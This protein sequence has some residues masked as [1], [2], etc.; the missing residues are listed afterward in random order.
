MIGYGS[1]FVVRLAKEEDIPKIME[2]TRTAFKAY[3]ELAGIND[4]KALNETAQDVLQ[5]IKGKMVLV[6]YLNDEPVG[7]V[8]IELRENNRAYLSRFGVDPAYQNDGVGKAM[9]SIVDLL[10]EQNGVRQIELHTASKIASLVRFYY[11]RG[12]YIESTDKDDGYIRAR[13]L[14]DYK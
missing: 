2:I 9:M 11:G 14:K 7:S 13:F 4:V 1:G 6:A 3:I 8:R 10:M 5:D 12:Y